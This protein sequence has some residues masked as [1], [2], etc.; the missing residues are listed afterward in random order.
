[1]R[2]KKTPTQGEALTPREVEVLALLREDCPTKELYERLGID[3]G[4]FAG[5]QK[6]LET[7]LGC[8]TRVGLAQYTVKANV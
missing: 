5:H 4:T 3:R 2:I 6:A 1:M 8:R 7:K